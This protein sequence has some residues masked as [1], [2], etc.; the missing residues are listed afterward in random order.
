MV[1]KHR[2][3]AVDPKTTSG[4]FWVN[5]HLITDDIVDLTPW[6]WTD[7][8]ECRGSDPDL[9]FNAQSI[10]ERRYLSKVCA[11][12]PVRQ[13]C[14]DHALDVGEDGFWAGTTREQRRLLIK[15]RYR[16]G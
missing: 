12:C 13:E 3:S 16:R 2:L 9:W 5:E 15:G 14:L 1:H 6:R 11:R 8:A 7:R 10:E 4:L